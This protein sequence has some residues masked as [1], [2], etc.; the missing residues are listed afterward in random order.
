MLLLIPNSGKVLTAFLLTLILLPSCTKKET[1]SINLIPKPAEMTVGNQYYKTDSISLFGQ[2]PNPSIQYTID[3]SYA[4]GNPEAYQLTVD[5]N[6][7]RVISSGEPGI[8]YARQTLLQI[9]SDKGVPY[10]NIKDFPRFRYRGYHLDVSRHFFPKEF[11]MKLI[12]VMSYY[13]L[14]TFHWHLTD[15][16]GWR[17]QIDKYPRLTSEAAFRPQHTWQEWRENGQQY[18]PEGTP[19]AYG[20]YYTKD[21]IREVVAYAASK[22]I[23]VIPEIE[24]P[25]HSE[26]IFIA[27]PELSCAGEPYKNDDYCIGNEK[28]FTFLENVLSEVM[29]LFPSRYIHIGGD[30]ANKGGW[31]TCPKCKARM[32]KEGLANVDELQSYMIH[33]IEKYLNDHGR[34]II[35]WDEILEGGLAPGATVMSWRGEAGGIEAARMGHDVIMTPSSYLY[36][37]FYQ[38]DPETQPYAIGGYTPIKRVYSYNPIPVDSLSPEQQKHI[39]GVQA[40]AW[41]EYIPESIHM[42]YMMFPRALALAE[43]AWTPQDQRDWDDF[44]PRVNKHISQLHQKGISAFSLSYD[45]DATMQVDTVNHEIKVFLDAEKYPAEI[46]YTTNG[47]IPTLSSPV[48]ERPITVKDSAIV[49]AAIFEDGRLKGEPMEKRVD[50]H[51]AINK[52]VEYNSRL[53]HGYMAGGMNALVDGY[54]GGLTYLDGVWQGYVNDLDCVIDM[55]EITDINYVSSRFMQLAGPN[56]YQPGHVELLLSD[57]GQEYVS[58]GVVKTGVS[59]ENKNLTFE[60]Y[61]FAG[62]WKARYIRIVAKEVQGGQFIFTDE[63]VVW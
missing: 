46:R 59:P 27:Y 2:Q 56:V 40:N 63:I 1:I 29:E 20:G 3:P 38:A 49:K 28:T 44:K 53:Y 25:G 47:N 39:I 30:E 55:G 60:E 35:G 11:V 58:V 24:M 23:T 6:G 26:E 4:S 14:N 62:K 12:D 7:V 52:P 50:Y 37:D 9:L 10:V 61:R 19:G 15:G 48:Y 54:R 41:A 57:D 8:F 43:V 21:E 17:I 51:R 33:R 34:Q 36:L 13:K 32:Q 18:V 16:A 42:E 31:K 22:H 45:I 5:D